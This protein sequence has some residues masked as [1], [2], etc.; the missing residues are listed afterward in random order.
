MISS[1]SKGTCNGKTSRI[2]VFIN[3][4]ELDSESV[5]KL[6][7]LINRK[8]GVKHVQIERNLIG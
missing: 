8:P 3:Q 2:T 7:K 1:D 4:G 5:S 6:A